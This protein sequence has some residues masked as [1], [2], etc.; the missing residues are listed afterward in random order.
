MVTFGDELV[1]VLPELRAE[2][3]SA[4]RDT[5]RIT[6]GTGAVTT[7]PDTGEVTTTP[8]VVY[9]GRC[10]VQTWEGFQGNPEAGTATFT[11]QRYSVH[12]PVAR[13]EADYRP[14][15]GDDVTVLSAELDPHLAD[16]EFG[17]VALLHKTLATAYRLG[18]S[19]GP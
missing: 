19:E 17:V 6:R 5:C 18:V 3:E 14:V 1:A 11:T 13:T 2:A 9:E 12:L 7:D 10:K 8:N 15:V 4:M 16:R